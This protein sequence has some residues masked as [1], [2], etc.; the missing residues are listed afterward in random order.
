MY[1]KAT[2]KFPSLMRSADFHVILPYHDGYPGPKR[3][4]P[5][6]YFL[7]GFSCNAEEIVFT[8]PFRQMAAL[9]SMAIIVPDGENS[10]YTDHPERVA[11]HGVYV[12][13]ELPKV[14]RKLFPCLSSERKDTFI[15]GISMGGYGAAALGLHY[16]E[17]FSRIALFSP[18]IEAD[19]LLASK[20]PDVPGGVPPCLLDTLLGGQA[21]YDLNPRLNPYVAVEEAIS[22]GREI[23]PIWMCCGE[24]DGLVLDACVRFSDFLNARQAPH[25]FLR[26]PGEHDFPFWDRHLEEGFR[27]LA[28]G[29]VQGV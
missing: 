16:H 3:P 26:A 24:Q 20:D 4:Y 19:T 6:L 21:A 27:F 14:V 10:F 11:R 7:P 18:S 25:T 13:E 22:H 2:A 29:F 23:P 5:T 12:G 28:E 17:T 8:L 15:G 1:L 9:F